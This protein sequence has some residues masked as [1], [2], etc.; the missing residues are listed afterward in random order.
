MILTNQK[1]KRQSKGPGQI[2][3]APNR[4]VVADGIDVG[5]GNKI[6]LWLFGFLY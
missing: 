3:D 6:P 5:F 1:V 4:Y 2:A